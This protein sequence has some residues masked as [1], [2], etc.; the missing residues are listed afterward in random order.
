MLPDSNRSTTTS[1][2]F[3]LVGDGQTLLTS[4][5][6]SMEH[7]RRFEPERL[8]QT[9]TN[10]TRLLLQE[11]R[12]EEARNYANEILQIEQSTSSAV[13]AILA[14]GICAA[15]A[16]HQIE[17]ESFFHQAAEVSRKINYPTGL[18]AALQHLVGK[19]LLV[20]GQFALAQTMLEESSLLQE[21]I[22]SKPTN[23]P[24]LIGLIYQIIGDRR[25]C[26][27]V[28]DG[29]V[30]QVEPG[31]RLAASYYFLWARLAIDEGELEQAK[32]YLRLGLRLAI[33]VG[34]LELNLWVRLEYSRYHRLMNEAPIAR[35]W[36]ED[37][38]HQAQQYD[39]AYFTGL[40]L[41]ERAQ[42]NW[43]SL[44]P[45]SAEAD[46]A[47]AMRILQTLPANYEL[48]L[49]YFLRAVWYR[50]ANRP[51]AESAWAE[52]VHQMNRNGYAFILEK[53]QELA[54]PIIATY[55][56]SK[57][58]T[59]RQSTE[60]LLRHLA[61][62]PPPPLRIATLGQFAVWKGRKR[63]ADQVWSRRKAGELFR[64]L[65]LQNNRAAGREV[66]IEALWP[67]HPSG[68]PSDL[69]HQ[70]TSALRHALEPDLPDKFPSRYLKVEGEHIALILPPGSAIDFEQ[71]ERVL[72]QA[73]QAHS[74]ERLQEA[75]N[76]YSGELFP[77]DQ[78][79]DWS[80]EKR[81]SLA[82]MRQRGLLAL[83]QAYLGQKQYYNVI[84][85]C[86]NIL[87]VDNWNEDAVL[88]VMQAY[89]GLQNV[90]HALQVYQELEQTL[91]QDL[92]IIPRVDLRTL[93]SELRHR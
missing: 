60:E 19:V 55:M 41:L 77:S 25:H 87:H 10:Y 8:A 21:E 3:E 93:Q 32:E 61:Q 44:D 71:F 2:D 70:A 31:T 42:A 47:E 49:A 7:A 5:Y 35:T 54:F 45:V 17:A 6:E 39:L 78:Y 29:M 14:L 59:V 53:E 80:V 90:P 66:I 56:R 28:L 74:T 18:A 22:G 26:R 64:Y 34:I 48:T 27:E 69:L 88:L 65:L 85:C 86:R 52:A 36:A 81:Q 92:G 12:F 73:V 68:N 63:I 33:R 46:L 4:A 50:Q 20:R 24:F 40:A 51:E 43:A 89:A 38:L 15:Q 62:V 67:D 9:M 30:Q 83:A 75:L 84:N 76:L 72:P 13:E 79:A 23:E 16:N 11:N 58:S 57:N 91:K 37:A 82:E 1:E